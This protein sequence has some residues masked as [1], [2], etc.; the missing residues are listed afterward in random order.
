MTCQ[1]PPW[2]CSKPCSSPL[3]RLPE[4]KVSGAWAFVAL[5]CSHSCVQIWI[6]QRTRRHCCKL[7]FGT[8]FT[9]RVSLEIAYVLVRRLQAKQD[10]RLD[11]LLQLLTILTL[12]TRL[13]ARVSRRL[14]NPYRPFIFSVGSRNC[15]GC[16]VPSCGRC[17]TSQLPSTTKSTVSIIFVTLY[18]ARQQRRKCSAQGQ[19][20]PCLSSGCSL[21]ATRGWRR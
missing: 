8:Y 18:Q 20:K 4:P 16:H 9:S 21:A 2:L 3:K 19:A 14:L 11:L 13:S 12:H 5:P 1:V 7:L 15:N 6:L 17:F 10:T